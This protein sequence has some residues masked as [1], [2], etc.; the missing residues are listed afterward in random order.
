[1]LI[2]TGS[3][4]KLVSLKL[5]WSTYARTNNSYYMDDSV[6]WSVSGL[7]YNG[8]QAFTSKLAL[9]VVNGIRTLTIL[10]T[11]FCYVGYGNLMW[12]SWV[13]CVHIYFFI[14]WTI[15]ASIFGYDKLISFWFTFYIYRLLTPPETPLYPSAVA[16]ESPLSSTAPLARES[17]LSSTAPL[18]RESPVSST[19][20]RG[21]TAVRSVSNTRPSRVC[22]I[23]LFHVWLFHQD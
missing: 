15:L 11:F 21:R 10:S 22:I 20:T 1:M 3:V 13:C 23:S 12:C 16:R 2:L 9:K 17:P 14:A 8:I 18:A 5:S 6:N 7:Y 19:S 4:S